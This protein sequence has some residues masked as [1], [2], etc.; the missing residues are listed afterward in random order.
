MTQGFYLHK[1][2]TGQ[3]WLYNVSLHIDERGYITHMQHG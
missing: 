3:E 1:V 2:F